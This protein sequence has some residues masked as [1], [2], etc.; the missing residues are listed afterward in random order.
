MKCSVQSLL[1]MVLFTIMAASSQVSQAAPVPTKTRI[2]KGVGIVQ[3]LGKPIPLDLKFT[4]STGKTI[5]L[6]DYFGKKP[7]VLVL[8][9]Y[10]CPM[11]CTLEL[12]ELAH[13][14]SELDLNPGKDFQVVTVSFDPKDTWQIAAE[15]KAEY[16]KSYKRPGAAANWHFLVGKPASID[17]LTQACGFHYRYDP[18]FHQYVH[19][20]GIMILTPKGDLS[21]YYFGINYVVKDLKFSLQQASGNNIGSYCDQLLLCCFSK[22]PSTGKYEPAVKRFM[23]FGGICTLVFIGSMWFVLF[24]KGSPAS[25][26]SRSKT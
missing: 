11:L 5:K 9:Y 7:V 15:K 6:G 4:D 17:P 24:R 22:N 10:S 20:S 21:C 14:L 8:V 1:T 2:F 23:A 16:L 3:E 25:R 12:N 18:Q 19:P 26:K 13:V